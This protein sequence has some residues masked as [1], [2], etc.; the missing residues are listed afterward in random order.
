MTSLAQ[1]VSGFPL[2]YSQDFVRIAPQ[3][4]A[5]PYSGTPATSNRVE[6]VRFRA[7][8]SSSS[9][10]RSNQTTG[11]ETSSQA[12][13]TIPISALDIQPGDLIETDP[14]DGRRWRVNGF[15]SRDVNPMTGWQPTIEA[16][17]VEVRGA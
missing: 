10:T 13:L 1:A 6:R 12:V 4:P 7:A 17:L 3:T 11:V 2:P 5:D 16:T 14:D 15:A 9:S 8:L